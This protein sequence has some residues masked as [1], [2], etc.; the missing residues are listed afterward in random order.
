MFN[1]SKDINNI[2]ALN[3][4]LKQQKKSQSRLGFLVSNYKSGHGYLK[5]QWVYLFQIVAIKKLSNLF[6]DRQYKLF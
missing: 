2:F 5:I 4:N 1:D 6:K 3:K